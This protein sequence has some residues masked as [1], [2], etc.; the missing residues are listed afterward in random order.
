M[1]FAL[2]HEVAGILESDDEVYPLLAVCLRPPVPRG[3]APGVLPHWRGQAG[4]RSENGTVA[5]APWEKEGHPKYSARS[6]CLSSTLFARFC[7]RR[8]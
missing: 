1:Q 8:S 6:K 7:Y 2:S 4:G 3:I 5:G